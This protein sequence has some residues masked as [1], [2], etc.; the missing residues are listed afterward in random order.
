MAGRSIGT[1]LVLRDTEAAWRAAYNSAPA[2]T[3][4]RAMRDLRDLLN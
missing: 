4:E 1:R 3:G 2:T